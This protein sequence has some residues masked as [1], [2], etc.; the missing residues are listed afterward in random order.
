MKKT[1]K[2]AAALAAFAGV[3]AAQPASA[4]ACT[5]SIHS[6]YISPDGYVTGYFTSP[7]VNTSLSVCNINGGTPVRTIAP[8]SGTPNVTI[9]SDS[10]KAT[11]SMMLTAKAGNKQLLWYI[12]V[13]SCSAIGGWAEPYP[14]AFILIN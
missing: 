7:T 11:Y 12:D 9:T 4:A 5:F 1:M 13:P 10:C 3:V 8:A 14:Q 6:L 2:I